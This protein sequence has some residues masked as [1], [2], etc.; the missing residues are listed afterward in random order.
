MDNTSRS[1]DRQLC[2]AA[3]A[4]AP[5]TRNEH[6][7]TTLPVR[8]PRLR[9]FTLRPSHFSSTLVCHRE[10]YYKGDNVMGLHCNDSKGSFD[11]FGTVEQK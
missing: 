7:S 4:V 3:C 9:R 1:H 2:C 8:R 10:L 6:Q 11:G 5:L